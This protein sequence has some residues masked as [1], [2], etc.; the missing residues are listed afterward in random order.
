MPTNGQ[1]IS[2]N[3]VI[4]TI[5][6][7]S[8]SKKR[9]T[10]AGRKQNYKPHMTHNFNSFFSFFPSMFIHVSFMHGIK[11]DQLTCWL[12]ENFTVYIKYQ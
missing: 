9:S 12:V 7:P 10:A 1:T 8:G 6:R 3:I 4:M 11:L 5:A 2:E